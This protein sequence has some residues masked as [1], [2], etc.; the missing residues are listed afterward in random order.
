MWWCLY[1]LM[2]EGRTH[3]SWIRRKKQWWIEGYRPDNNTSSSQT[4]LAYVPS[5]IF[6][7]GN[8]NSWLHSTWGCRFVAESLDRLRWVVESSIL[9]YCC[10]YHTLLKGADLSGLRALC[11]LI[12]VG[13]LDGL[14]V[15]QY[16][17]CM[18]CFLNCYNNSFALLVLLFSQRCNLLW[19]EFNLGFNKLA[20]SFWMPED[21][22]E[23][24]R[25]LKTTCSNCLFF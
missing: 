3:P 13:I 8:T 16:L 10:F 1:L 5:T 12:S 4:E 22:C 9:F 23:V 15:S 19:Q 20:E 21:E 17:Y 25:H 18:T 7:I 6:C 2:L 11:S 24:S 14:K